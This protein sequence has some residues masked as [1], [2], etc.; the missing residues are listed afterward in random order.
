MLQQTNSEIKSV[1]SSH[2]S[3]KSSTF[4]LCAM[5]NDAGWTASLMTCGTSVQYKLDTGAQAN[6]LPRET[7]GRLSQRPALKKTQ[8]KLLTYGS[9]STLPVDG[10]C[11]CQVAPEKGGARYL[12]FF[13]VPLAAEP[14]LGL[15]SCQD[16]GLIKRLC[17][18]EAPEN[19]D[20]FKAAE[21]SVARDYIDIFTGI[22]HVKRY[23]YTIQVKKDSTTYAATAPRRV[24][25]PL[26]DKVKAELQRMVESG[27]IEEVT[28]PTAWVSPMVPV[29]KK[30]GSVR[31]C[32]D[33]TRLNHSVQ[34]EQ[35]QLPTADQLF[36][37]LH[38]AKYFSTLDAASGF[39]QI[40]LSEDCSSLTTFISPFGRYRFK[41]LPFGI[42]SGPEVF[43]RAMQHILAGQAGAECYMDGILVWGSTKEEHDTRLRDVL[44]RCRDEGVKF[45]LSKCVFLKQQVK[46]LV[47]C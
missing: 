21:N 44:N 5:D 4:F 3:V 40:P 2:D 18:T 34:R 35:F 7:Y 46:F 17:T 27:V 10:Q 14:L 22:G 12:R 25:Y 15:K 36:A 29:P 20:V 31:I 28:E 30:N 23:S 39:Y 9:S 19:S 41:R 42:T 16:L 32:V 33:L 11:I 47:M 38:G 13:V 26:L 6:I 43:H 1:T 24:P 37:S 45:N 8:T